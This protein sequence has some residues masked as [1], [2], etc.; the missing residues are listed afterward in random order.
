MRLYIF[1]P[2]VSDEGD[3]FGVSVYLLDLERDHIYNLGLAL[4]L[5]QRK[6]KAMSESTTFL[7]DV[8]S[9]WIRRQDYVEEHGNP[10][11]GTLVEALKHRRLSQNGIAKQIVQDKPWQKCKRLPPTQ[12]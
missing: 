4:G 3:S 6:V 9:A 7:D 5:S 8:L 2:C 12:T 10:S 11:W 1:V